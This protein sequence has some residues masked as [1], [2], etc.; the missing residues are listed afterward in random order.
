MASQSSLEPKHI[1]N[2]EG[3]DVDSR[4][5]GAVY[6]GR[7]SSNQDA[8]G[9]G[10]GVELLF[11][12][13]LA[14]RGAGRGVEVIAAGRGLLAERLLVGDLSLAVGCFFSVFAARILRS[15]VG[16]LRNVIGLSIVGSSSDQ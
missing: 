8:V 7:G 16:V 2:G 13:G 15:N 1:A 9:R 4:I 5:C 14:V 12:R 11:G 3:D 6:N 10:L